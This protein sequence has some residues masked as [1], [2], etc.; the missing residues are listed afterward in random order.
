MT[1]PWGRLLVVLLGM[2][3]ALALAGP[4][5][6]HVGGEEAGSNFDGR[7]RAVTPAVP[8]LGVRVLQFGDELEL[9]NDSA[10]EVV[11]PGYQGEPY[12]RIGPDGVWRNT[13]SPATYI[14]LDRYARVDLPATADHR[15]DPE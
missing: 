7:I 4:A 3:A 2:L 14:N 1:R 6:A 13:R 8:G 12:L 11:V 10:S 9:V 15:A 5:T